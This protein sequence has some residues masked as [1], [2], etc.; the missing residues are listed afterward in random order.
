MRDHTAIRRGS[1]DLENIA[2]APDTVALRL[3][4]SGTRIRVQSW[5]DCVLPPAALESV[6]GAPWPTVVG[7]SSGDHTRVLCLGPADWLVLSDAAAGALVRALETAKGPTLSV[8]DLSQGI[9]AIEVAGAC[10]RDLLAKACG[11]DV[12]ARSLRRGV[13]AR[14][15]FAGIAVIVYAVGEDGVFHCYV[16]R[17]Y[18]QYLFQ[19]LTDG[20]AEFLQASS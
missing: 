16:S 10:A 17:S 14:T 12:H 9:V 15:R 6:V 7:C 1:E 3:L 20:A 5:S 8:T 11:L 19:W 2:G 4:W 13:C 18:V